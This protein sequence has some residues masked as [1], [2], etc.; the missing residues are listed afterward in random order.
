MFLFCFCCIKCIAKSNATIRIQN[1]VNDGFWEMLRSLNPESYTRCVAW[2]IYCSYFPPSF[3][4][5][6]VYHFLSFSESMEM[7]CKTY[8]RPSIPLQQCNCIGHPS[9][10][11]SLSFLRNRGSWDFPF[12]R[13][14]HARNNHA[15]LTPTANRSDTLHNGAPVAAAVD[16]SGYTRLYTVKVRYALIL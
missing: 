8:W 13:P 7:I 10:A 4:S 2:P 11:T 12:Q 1:A 16:A 14:C 5:L 6:P 15:L 3:L 9:N